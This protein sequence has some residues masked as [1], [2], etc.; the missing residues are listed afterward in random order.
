MFK[1]IFSSALFAWGVFISVSGYQPGVLINAN[2]LEGWV[3]FSGIFGF[4]PL[5]ALTFAGWLNRRSQA[6]A[7][8]RRARELRAP[9]SIALSKDGGPVDWYFSCPQFEVSV[10][11]KR[12]EIRLKSPMA[13]TRLGRFSGE[14]KT[15]PLDVAF[16]MFSFEAKVKDITKTVY[17]NVSTTVGTMVNDQY[18]SVV[19]PTHGGY[20]VE[21]STGF[22]EVQIIQCDVVTDIQGWKP[23]RNSDGSFN[24]STKVAKEAR[25]NGKDYVATFFNVDWTAATRFKKEWDEQ[26]AKIADIEKSRHADMLAKR[27]EADEAELVEILRAGKAAWDAARGI[28]AARMGELRAW[29]D[30]AA[31]FVDGSYKIDGQ[32][33]WAIAAD[34]RGRAAI[35]GQGESWAGAPEVARARARIVEV[36]PAVN[37][38]S[39]VLALDIELRD[40]AFERERLAKRRFRI[41]EGRKREQLIEWA[42][43]L[44]ILAK[45]E[46]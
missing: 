23:T 17:K 43:R 42:D 20:S 35:M 6:S 26:L 45:E 32:I 3:M 15:G 24:H 29:A 38:Q 30:V 44:N 11:F 10:D 33:E 37:G 31:D 36:V 21:Q 5:L 25:R 34:R 39:L 7:K 1:F 18:V 40:E 2:R 22:C 14:E 41:M 16:P 27:R 12:E 4:G 9:G 13:K 28:Y 8:A 46:A 19:V